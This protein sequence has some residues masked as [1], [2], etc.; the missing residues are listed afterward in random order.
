M[1]LENL[2]KLAVSLT[3]AAALT[4][5]LPEITRAVQLAQIKLLHESRASKWESPDLLYRH[6]RN[7]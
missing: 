2:I 6:L 7:R 5:H 3:I 1:G 4:G